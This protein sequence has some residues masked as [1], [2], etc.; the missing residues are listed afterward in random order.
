VTALGTPLGALTV[1]GNEGPPNGMWQQHPSVLARGSVLGRGGEGICGVGIG[2]RQDGLAVG[3]DGG[4]QPEGGGPADECE[5]HAG[6]WGWRERSL[7]HPFADHWRVGQPLRY[8]H[9]YQ[10][11][12]TPTPPRESG[13]AN[14]V[15]TNWEANLPCGVLG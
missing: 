1:R 2:Q 12:M 9:L 15:G 8:K 13:G 7:G 6:A 11:G 4:E 5:G 3:P 14:S 10:V